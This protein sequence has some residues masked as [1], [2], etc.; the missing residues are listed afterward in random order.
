MTI[1]MNVLVLSGIVVKAPKLSKS[2]A[3]IQHLHFV[4]E[5]RSTQIE[6][7]HERRSYVR[8][9]VVLSGT[10]APIW[11]KQLEPGLT[12]TV[13]GFLNRQDDQN[14]LAKLVLHAQQLNLN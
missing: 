6:A 1:A 10:E 2:P 4:L 8:I 13:K 11:A 7:Q 12:V 9:Q 5:H 14:G 3:G